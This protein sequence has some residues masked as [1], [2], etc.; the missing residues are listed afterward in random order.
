MVLA[1]HWRDRRS[2]LA[3][4]GKPIVA[5]SIRMAQA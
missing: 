4:H 3:Q 5:A 2:A 1:E